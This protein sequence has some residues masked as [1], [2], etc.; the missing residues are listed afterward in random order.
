MPELGY[1]PTNKYL[2]PRA[3]AVETP[4]PVAETPVTPAKLSPFLRW[5]DAILS[6]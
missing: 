3:R 4:S 5:V 2:P 1:Q 6:R